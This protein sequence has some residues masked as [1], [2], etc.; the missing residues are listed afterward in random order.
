MRTLIFLAGTIC[1]DS[2]I[3]LLAA[4]ADCVICAD[5]GLAHARRLGL[6][7][8]LLVGDLDS[9]I[10]QDLA[11][12]Q[13]RQIPLRTYSRDK[14]E[15]DAELA[16]QAALE[17]MPGP[18]ATGEPVPR[19]IILA[20]A[21]GDRPDHVLANQLLVSRL[22]EQTAALGCRFR[23]TDGRSDLYTLIGGQSLSLNLPLYTERPLAVSAVTI[24]PV[25]IGLTYAGLAF[26]LDHAI[27]PLGS[28]RG[29]SN[30]VVASPVHI[31]LTAGIILIL[32]T[33]E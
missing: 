1:D 16:V 21:S 13:A 17:Q 26:P 28:T 8:D 24:S 10:A 29:L 15:T 27:L 14:D 32:V 7:P 33:P 18:G 23:L 9:V 22:A 6:Q 3:R 31:S 2:P 30:R 12:A 11:W 5:G 19:E 25:A 4:Q 20:G